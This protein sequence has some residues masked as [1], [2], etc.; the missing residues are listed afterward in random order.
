MT[1]TIDGS[2]KA[3]M[4]LDDEG[5][6]VFIFRKTLELAGYGVFAFTDPELALEH[7]KTN[8]DRYGLIISDVRM[9]K[10]DGIE[11]V[12]KVRKFE[13]TISIILMSAF[14][15][16]E[17]DIQPE[18][19]IAELLQ[20]PITPIMLSETVAKFIKLPNIASPIDRSLVK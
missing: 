1:S 6:I 4:V 13:P 8:Q 2:A 20:K 14:S 12:E 7:L 5:D 11:F 17:L 3:I 9:P 15:M 16:A 19:K 18:L 10:M